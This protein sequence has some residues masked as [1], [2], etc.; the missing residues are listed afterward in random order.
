MLKRSA[1]LVIRAVIAGFLGM[2][3]FQSPAI[4]GMI[5]T[6]QTQVS[7]DR[8][9]VKAFIERGDA[10]QQLKSLGVAPDAVQGRVDA[11]TDEEV[12]VIAGKIDS[13]P[14]GGA[15]SNNQWIWIIGGIL[16]LILIL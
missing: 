8:E 6:D 4:G 10:A 2:C 15:L 12:R 14:A 3:V 1:G 7:Q 11:M 5:G 9:R 16:L 13:L